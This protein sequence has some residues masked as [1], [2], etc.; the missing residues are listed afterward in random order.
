MR[1]ISFAT[2]DAQSNPLFKELKVLKIPDIF[3]YQI[4]KLMYDY[5]SG[6]LP[7]ALH[8]FTQFEDVHSYETRSKSRELFIVPSVN[9]T[10]FGKNS[11]FFL[12]PTAWNDHIRNS[13]QILEISSLNV[14]KRYLKKHFLDSYD[15]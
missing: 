7:T 15:D 1:L 11:I 8:S 13:Q 9:S 2:Y 5:Y 6:K 3:S 4:L 14:L 12:G 10:N